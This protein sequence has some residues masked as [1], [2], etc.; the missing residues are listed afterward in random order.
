[1]IKIPGTESRLP[2]V[3]QLIS[4]GII[5]NSIKFTLIV[6]RLY[7]RNLPTNRKP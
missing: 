4:K 1:M 5:V 7:S 2:A 6:L 3:K